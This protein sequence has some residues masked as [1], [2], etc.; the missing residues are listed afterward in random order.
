MSRYE[1]NNHHQPK[2]IPVPVPE[3]NV[4]DYTMTLPASRGRH[5]SRINGKAINVNQKSLNIHHLKYSIIVLEN[6]A[7]SVDPRALSSKNDVPIL[8]NKYAI[9]DFIR[10]ESLTEQREQRNHRDD[11]ENRSRSM[12]RSPSHRKS[13]YSPS[14]EGSPEP[15]PK[16]LQPNERSRYLAPPLPPDM[17]PSDDEECIELA[18]P[19]RKP[20]KRERKEHLRPSP[21]I[22]TPM[23]FAI[24]RQARLIESFDEEG[25]YDDECTDY[26]SDTPVRPVPIWLCVF[27]VIGYIIAGAFYFTR[28]E[29]WSFLDSAYFC[30]ITLTTIG[31]SNL[32]FVFFIIKKVKIEKQNKNDLNV[33]LFCRIW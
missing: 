1:N 29:N 4:R 17:R 22:M 23:G 32:T 11:R 6:R 9:D 10:R 21:R 2:P 15:I 14:R 18:V 7:Q 30:F 8:C 24:H 31:N 16:R 28:T 25:G 13:L 33:S 26:V 19:M 5:R 3:V 27:L 12:P 20:K